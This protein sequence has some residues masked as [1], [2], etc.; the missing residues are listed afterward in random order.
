MKETLVALD[1]E[2]TGLDPERDE[3]IEIGA[4]KFEGERVLSTWQSLVKPYSLLPYRI[5]LLTGLSQRELDSAPPLAAVAGELLAFLGGH[6]LVGQ[7]ISSDTDFLSRKGIPIRNPSYDTFEMANLLLPQL[8]E[9]GLASLAKHFGIPFDVQHRALPDAMAA[10]EVFLALLGEAEKIEL[11]LIAGINHLMAGLEWPLAPLFREMERERSLKVFQDR[12]T[13]SRKPETSYEGMEFPLLAAREHRERPLAPR[14]QRAPLDLGRLLALLGPGGELAQRFPGYE[15]RPEQM[16]MMLAV[17]KAL[18]EG[19]HLMVEAGTGVG[20]SLAY[21]LPSAFFTLQ[22]SLPLVVSTNTINLQ[23]QLV[24]KD[25]PDLCATLEG[26]L[27]GLRVTQLKGRNNYLCL[28]RFSSLL[29]S[30]GPSLEEAKA[31]ARLMIWLSSTDS[32]DRG[33]LNLKPLEALVW[34]RVSAQADNCLASHCTHLERGTCFLQRARRR[35]E[36]AHILVVNHA[37]LLSDTA[38]KSRILPDYSYLVIDEAHHLEEVATEQWGWRLGEAE[39]LELL[40]RVG[41]GG[42]DRSSG[43]LQALGDALRVSHL[44]EGERRRL[45]GMVESMHPPLEAARLRVSDFFQMVERFV[46]GH[47]SEESGEYDRRLRLIKAIRVQPDWSQ[48]EIAWENLHLVLREVERCLEGLR[49]SLGDQEGSLFPGVEDM[50]LDAEALLYSLREVQEGLKKVVANPLSG[51]VY[52]I[53][54]GGQDNLVTLHAAP[55]QVAPLLQSQLFSQKDCIIL[56]SATLSTEGTFEYLKERLG[57]FPDQELILGAPFDYRRSTLIYLPQDLPQPT[58]AR[59]QRA[60]EESLLELCRATQG[61]ALVLFTSHSALRATYRAIKAALEEEGILVLG[62]GLDGSPKNLL[63]VLKGNPRSVLL[64]ASSFWEGVDVVGESLS[65]LVMAKLPFSVPTDPLFAARA[66]T[67]EEPF[68]QYALPQAVLRF[69]QGFG[70]LIRS[71]TDRGVVVMLD[72]RLEARSYGVAFLDSLPQCTLKKG[73]LRQ[74]AAEV[75]AWLERRSALQA[76]L[77]PG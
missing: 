42:G 72:R 12:S 37:L 76:S 52:W 38:A 5:R 40:Y 51:E 22:N 7:S 32:G 61:R 58:Q 23:E 45:E 60:V 75:N 3:I 17:A 68:Q 46:R 16:R 50:Q 6:R 15:N 59:Y 54:L 19:H 20:K 30:G 25:L 9:H 63:A 27:E 48:V 29:K 11:L 53:S 8:P 55:L 1:L 57:F 24:G 13:L 31:L 71:A 2:T 35:A 33:E 62:Q 4:V 14:E 74:M 28:R 69:K 41:H 49:A 66:E 65:V 67:F 39:I 34:R 36:R 44:P 47:A 43:F 70:R 26:Q 73:L 10:K 21:L 18:N 64:G 77:E 56:T